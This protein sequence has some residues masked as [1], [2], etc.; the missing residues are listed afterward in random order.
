MARENRS[1]GYDRI[2]GSLKHLGYTISDQTVG[3]ILKRHD[4]APAPERKK[5][6]TWR[7]FIRFH[8]DVLVA[9]CFFNSEVWSWFGPTISYLLSSIHLSR[10]LAHCVAIILY[11]HMLAVQALMCRFL[12][13]ILDVRIW[14]SLVAQSLQ[15]GQNGKAVQQQTGAE[16]TLA[17]V[18][19]PRSQDMA[20][21]VVLSSARRRPIHDGPNRCQHRLGGLQEED[22]REA[23]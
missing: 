11:R 3:N 6:V 18:R 15:A 19:P 23:A 1:W 21:M 12:D 17:E 10:H 13:L 22:Y 7:E 5:T 8:W 4:I 16:V 9:T 2:Q 20:K 14:M